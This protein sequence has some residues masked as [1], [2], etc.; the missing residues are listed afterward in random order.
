MALHFSSTLFSCA[1]NLASQHTAAEP[2]Y[3]L[4][5]MRL[6]EQV[7]AAFNVSLKTTVSFKTVFP[8]SQLHWYQQLY[9]MRITSHRQRTEY[10]LNDKMTAS[11]IVEDLVGDFSIADAV[12]VRL[13]EQTTVTLPLPRPS[14]RAP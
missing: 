4:T 13:R 2:T 7:S 10:L 6:R 3:I 11:F 14:V 12:A 1:P 5:H 9:N 8:G